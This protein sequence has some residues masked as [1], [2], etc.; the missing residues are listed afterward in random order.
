MASPQE[1]QE[2]AIALEQK[3]RQFAENH[4]RPG[5]KLWASQMAARVNEGIPS[6]DPETARLRQAQIEHA[7][8]QSL[9]SPQNLAALKT[10][11][12][13][14]HFANQLS[15]AFQQT[16]PPAASQTPAEMDLLQR[17]L[18][19]L[20]QQA[21]ASTRRQTEVQQVAEEGVPDP[22]KV[23]GP[24][25]LA[26]LS[27]NDMK[28]AMQASE[29]FKV[30]AKE[31]KVIGQG[32]ETMGYAKRQLGERTKAL[33]A[34]AGR[35]G[36]L[37]QQVYQRGEELGINRQLLENLVRANASAAE[38]Q[39]KMNTTPSQGIQESLEQNRQ[40]IATLLEQVP[41]EHR[42]EIAELTQQLGDKS[43]K[44]NQSIQADG[45]SRSAATSLFTNERYD[46]CNNGSP[47]IDNSFLGR[48]VAS[49][50]VDQLIGIGVCSEEKFGV[51]EQGQ[52][53]GISV[54]VD[55]AQ[56]F[57]P[58]VIIVDG[59]QE[60]VS[61]LLDV[62]YSDPQVQKGL[63]DM[64]A[65]DYITGQ[66]DR[67]PGNIVIDPETNSVK[68]IDNDLAFPEAER[69]AT[70]ESSHK[71][72][73][74]LP[75]YLHRETADKIMQI[76][77]DQL[78]A[79]LSGIT[80]PNDPLK[81]VLSPQEIEG[82]VKR[83]GELQDHIQK[84]EAEGKVVDAFTQ[85][86][87]QD[88]IDSQMDA[89]REHNKLPEGSEIDI[90]SFDAKCPK[91]SYLGAI[92]IARMDAQNVA[93]IVGLESIPG[94]D[95]RMA[96][97]DPDYVQSK[98]GPAPDQQ[99]AAAEHRVQQAQAKLQQAE[100]NL[101]EL[102]D[103]EQ[104]GKE[105]N[106]NHLR[107][108]YQ[109]RDDA[110]AALDVASKE[111]R[112]LA[113]KTGVNAPAENL[114][115]AEQQVQ[116]ENQA[117]QADQQAPAVV[118]ADPAQQA[119]QKLAQIAQDAAGHGNI[120]VE[121]LNLSRGGRLQNSGQLRSAAINSRD[122]AGAA[123]IAGDQMAGTVDHD[124]LNESEATAIN[125]TLQQLGRGSDLEVAKMYARADELNA[126]ADVQMK[127]RDIALAVEEGREPSP[128]Q[129]QA[130]NQSVEVLA[131]CQ[132]K[133]AQ[134]TRAVNESI[135][136]RIQ[137]RLEERVGPLLDAQGY[138]PA[139]RDASIKALTSAAM[140]IDVMKLRD[141]DERADLYV[142]QMVQGIQE[143]KF[144]YPGGGK[145]HQAVYRAFD[146]TAVSVPDGSIAIKPAGGGQ[147]FNERSAN[148]HIENAMN[149]AGLEIPEPVHEATRNQALQRQ[150]EPGRERIAAYAAR[151]A[152][153]ARKNEVV[154]GLQGRMQELEQRKEQLQNNPS[155]A[156]RLKAVLKHGPK[157]IEGEIA[158]ID[159]KLAAAQRAIELEKQNVGVEQ[160]KA[161]LQALKDD[162]Q[163]GK[164]QLDQ[165]RQDIKAAEE[166]IKRAGVEANL[167]ES[168]LAPKMT[169]SQR[170]D[171]VREA[172]Q[173][174]NVREA[175]KSEQVGLKDA[176]KE[177]KAQIK[178]EEKAVSV[179]EK[180]AASPNRPTAGGHRGGHSV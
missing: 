66:I 34:E 98:G 22:G 163:A 90:A 48:A 47:D 3:S 11:E 92:E 85:Q 110:Q 174:V 44:L 157:G 144:D 138:T 154:R 118:V 77:P 112:D 2:Q 73:S 36:T 105:L 81:P 7:I 165:V 80:S 100:N 26:G 31:G 29:T 35:N 150:I 155:A 139:E 103:G 45:T 134:A 109:A 162:Y 94:N 13:Q 43:F 37:T 159:K 173:A 24:D 74:N 28:S 160:Q 149:E 180:L 135:E 49:Y 40:K 153:T 132:Q 120:S 46:E 1:I 179:R 172:N 95:V 64:E 58:D 12:Q 14:Q 52:V 16:A 142:D 75:Q 78:R 60:A 133:S 143:S 114:E 27:A 55:G 33:A 70:L 59:K 158:S 126:T 131:A 152:E 102:L 69:S 156:D 166:V 89:L 8:I 9:A 170:D 23:S 68:G 151:E 82:A 177:L 91:T 88:A 61:R 113:E 71:A 117:V 171:F 57:R 54:A 178:E 4:L 62:D 72:V 115:A 20:V 15:Q 121:S 67:H 76:T 137:Q 129:I 87:Y 50:E 51:D 176:Q 18:P 123:K 101:L 97:R 175:L 65:L 104:V 146:S 167:E 99:L 125:G 130:F 84:L 39:H 106:P 21:A 119:G 6:P 136:A 5:A 93:N 56:V 169:D 53:I 147:T 25:D 164:Q 145:V 122:D 86:T 83:L 30:N 161:G 38:N 19:G 111:A 32:G 10:P 41:E 108:L 17:Q 128:A 79:R 124:N 42:A 127:F 168:G 116:V 140:D 107:S 96:P 63:Y 141:T 148:R